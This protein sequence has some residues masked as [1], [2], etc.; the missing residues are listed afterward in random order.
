MC[1][2]SFLVLT[3]DSRI[4]RLPAGV[5]ASQARGAG[6][7]SQL[8]H[9]GECIVSA[10][11]GSITCKHVFAG[12]SRCN[13]PCINDLCLPLRCPDHHESTPAQ[14]TCH[15]VQHALTQCCGYCGVHR[16]ATIHQDL[17]PWT[18]LVHQPATAAVAGG[19]YS[20]AM[21]HTDN[22]GRDDAASYLS[23]S[24]GHYLP[25]PCHAERA[26]PLASPYSPC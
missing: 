12:C 15:R 23:P 25:L 4:C 11:A 17:H 26:P 13:F 24:S 16:I 5:T 20:S 18:S 8:C 10:W 9:G 19:C 2:S 22:D 6:S 3:T 21:T 14:P 1:G 7:H